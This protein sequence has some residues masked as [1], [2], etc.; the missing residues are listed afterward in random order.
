MRNQSSGDSCSGRGGI[1]ALPW[2]LLALSLHAGLLA[3]L[4]LGK[5]A[6]VEQLPVPIQVV[7]LDPSPAAASSGGQPQSVPLPVKTV[8]QKPKAQAAPREA[9]L[10]R[11]V[12][13][14]AE[15]A[16][17]AVTEVPAE[18]V[19]SSNSTPSSVSSTTTAATSGA[20]PAGSPGT[21]H[22]GGGG[23]LTDAK[24]DA[25]YLQNPAPAYPPLSR[26]MGEEGKVLL[27]AYVLP[28]GKPETV[29][30]KKGSGSSRLDESALAAVR[31]WR[32]VPARRGA[33]A[34]AAWVLIPISFRLES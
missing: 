30:V 3:A 16:E 4:M 27:R 11:P 7:L 6:P 10:P 5:A 20:A 26:R 21:S 13:K 28:N 24:F 18:S 34:V 22:Q 9:V 31:K 23:E 12:P 33:E 14:S 19:A 17:K 2:V 29:E 8:Q 25:D 15:S 32:F 1:G